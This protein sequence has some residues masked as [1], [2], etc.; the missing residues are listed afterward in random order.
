M[1][2][3][4][5]EKFFFKV[6]DLSGNSVMC[7][8]KMKFCKNVRKMS[9]NF[10]FQPDE[11]RIFDPDVSSLLH[12]LNFLLQY[13]QGNLNLHQGN[14]REFWSVLIVCERCKRPLF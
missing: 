9:E 12:S 3:K 6:R 10:T 14:V 7:Q 2:G 4:C 11:A 13:C 5:Q 1:P 8:G